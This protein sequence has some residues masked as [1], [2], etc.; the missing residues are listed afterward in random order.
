MDMWNR[1]LC[2]ACPEVLD[3]PSL[4]GVVVDTANPLDMGADSVVV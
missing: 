1:G 3:Q 2:F 4:Y